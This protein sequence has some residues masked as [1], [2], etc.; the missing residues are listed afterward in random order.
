[1]NLVIVGQRASGKTSAGKALA[2]RVGAPFFD[3][4]EQV[5]RTVGMKIPRIFEE[6]GEAFF[7]EA[8]REAVS[9]AASLA[10]HVIAA[11]GGALLDDANKALLCKAGTVVWLDCGPESLLVRRQAEA[12]ASGAD[13]RPAL[14]GVKLENEIRLLHEQR[15]HLYSKASNKRLDTEKMSIEEVVD[16]LERVWQQVPHDDIR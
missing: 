12:E 10:D 11:G 2:R 6:R 14:T 4:D 8:E 13:Q 15:R 16:E 9:L 1:M 3:T 7:R 5:E